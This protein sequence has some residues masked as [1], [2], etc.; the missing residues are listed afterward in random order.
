MRR[1]KIARFADLNDP[2]ELFAVELSEKNHRIPLSGFKDHMHERFGLICFSKHWE[3]PVLWSHY[4]ERHRGVCLGFDVPDNLL[5]Q[6]TY[7]PERLPFEF[8]K[9]SN[10]PKLKPESVA[11]LLHTKF[12]D[13]AYEEEYRIF[14]GLDPNSVEGGLHFLSF[15][16]ELILSEVILGPSCPLPYDEVTKLVSLYD[17]NIKVTRARLAFESFKIVPET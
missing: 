4:A 13:W 2:F 3:N 7:T 14:V 5:Q 16:K 10:R 1:I 11:A 6:V 8:E 17:G 15:G 12:S 9:N